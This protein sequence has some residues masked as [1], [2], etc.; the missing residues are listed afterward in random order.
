VNVLKALAD[1][2]WATWAMVQQAISTLDFD[3]YKYGAW[4]YR[5][6]RTMFY[7]PEWALWLRRL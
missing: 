7:H 6:A 5:R 4:K 1:M 3:F 2:K